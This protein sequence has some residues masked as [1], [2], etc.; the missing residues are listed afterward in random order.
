VTGAAAALAL[1]VITSESAFGQGCVAV[2]PMG[3][4][5]SE[6]ANQAT[7]LLER[8]EWQ[9]FGSYQYY[10]SFRHFRGDH[11]EAE[12]VENGTEVININHATNLGVSYGLSNR[13]A[14]TLAVP[15]IYYDRSSLYEHYGNSLSAN[16]TQARFHTGAQGI[17]DARLS[18]NY[19]LFD[20]MTASKGN[21]AIGLGIKAPTGDSNVED[22]FHKTAEDGSDSLVTK[23]VDQSIQ[24]GDGGWGFTVQTEGY[25]SVFSKAS[26]YF[27]GF[28]L[29]NPREVN[30]TPQSAT[31]FHSVADQYAAR[32]GLM[33]AVLP[34]HGLAASLG[35]RLEG[36]PSEDLIGG[37]EGRRRP[38]Y[39]VS[40]EPGLSYRWNA[41]NLALNVPIALYRNRT[42]SV[43]DK[44]RTRETGEF[45]NGDA[46]FADYLVNFTVS[47][48]F[49]KKHAMMEVEPFEE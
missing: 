11:E 21:V 22:T 34:R 38:G 44:E 13:I 41:V 17:G 4:A 25:R 8:G 18:G 1:L 19:W 48:Q 10:R 20:P 32:L 36:V 27:N 40:I 39:I 23:A 14:L 29:F 7:G 31:T 49:G 37:S 30:D 43:D 45:T 46:A 5:S 47:T 26:V 3:C 2:R 16:P 15:L 24:L 33:Y 42:Q 35:G 12:R 28:Y 9:L 6:Y